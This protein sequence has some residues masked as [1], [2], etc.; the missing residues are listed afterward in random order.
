MQV[1]RDLVIRFK[2]VSPKSQNGDN[3]KRIVPHQQT[4]L[5]LAISLA[6]AIGLT[7]CGGSDSPPSEQL[8]PIATSSVRTSTSLNQQGWRFIF[9]V[10]GSMTEVDAEVALSGGGEAVHLPHTW[11]ATDAASTNSTTDYLRGVGWYRIE[12]N[13]NKDASSQWLHFDA[14]SIVADVWLNGIN[15]GSHSGAFSAFRFDV[16]SALRHG[17]NTLLVKVNNSAPING[18]DRTAVAPL[19]GDF[20][21]SGGLYRG[22]SL[23]GVPGSAHFA[24]NDL[25]SSGIFVTT[26]SLGTVT[27]MSGIARANASIR[28]K[29]KLNSRRTADAAFTVRTALLD[30]AGQVVGQ[31]TSNISIG[32]GRASELEQV[33]EL[34][35]V[36]LWN[37][38]KDPYLHTVVV[39]VLDT[40][41][42]V[43]D[44]I[45]E[46]IGV[47]VMSFN[48]DTGFILNGQSYPL[49]GVNMHQDQLGKA[50]AVDPADIDDRLNTI[51]DIG[52]NTVRMA[53]Y[54][55]SKYAYEFADNLGLVVWAENGFVDATL[56]AADCQRTSNVPDS[57]SENLKQQT[58]EL[59]RQNFNHASIGMWSIGNEIGN[60]GM[61]QGVDTVTPL[62]RELAV[63]TRQEDPSRASTLADSTTDYPNVGV[64][65]NSGITDTWALNRYFGWY[66]S[67]LD[68][69]NSLGDYL[70]AM[71]A[72]YPNLPMGISEYGA[73]A[74]LTH[75]TDNPMGGVV[76]S[77]DPTATVAR[78]G[79]SFGT[80]LV[81]YQPEGYAN[82]VHE[83]NYAQMLARPYIWGT[84]VWNMF[85][86]GSGIRNEG[87]L[88]GVNT[89]GLVTFDGKTKKDPYYFYK[90]AWRSDIPVVHINGRR[91]TNRAY[92]LTDVRVYSNADS[93]S[94]TLNGV[95][96]GTMT[97]EQCRV[98]GV[99]TSGKPYVVPNV[100][101]YK[102]IRLSTGE[103]NLTASGVRN[104][105]TAVDS[106]KWSL[107][108]DNA[109]NY[110]IAAGQPATGM[111]QGTANKTF[112]SDNFF[113]GGRGWPLIPMGSSAGESGMTVA[114]TASYA[115]PTGMDARDTSIWQT[116]RQ[117][118]AFEYKLPLANGTYAV[119]LGFLEPKPT[120]VIGSRIFDVSADGGS[121]EVVVM[122]G[123]DVL[124]LAGSHR[125]AYVPPPF[126]V[127]VT[128]GLLKLKFTGS[129]GEAVVS[130]IKVVRQ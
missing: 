2:Q 66:F 72:K 44:R 60:K 112:G 41:G 28:V 21:R 31:R 63:L 118:S 9:D 53:H 14:A 92:A 83:Q 122:S 20:N 101:E 121:G 56:T 130:N 81:L 23:I 88:R 123:M 34:S 114:G 26:E 105:K 103:N 57:F 58:I 89:K 75:Q 97:A 3:V 116:F 6:G 32:A 33:I 78:F 69:V 48:V 126:N 1:V 16:T 27:E 64:I 113:T 125:R 40:S 85:D 46:K 102:N 124:A 96:L 99:D 84:Y 52:A 127:V 42:N 62:A 24:L 90:A 107:N 5:I 61:C 71:H 74:A 13:H 18:A 86:F 104:G 35:N 95:S 25:G 47:R 7:A 79:V 4:K 117:G 17:S 111:R 43:V 82:F 87:D 45:T 128:N 93:T 110:Y 29:S 120:A 50:W 10:T 59:I 38:I 12:F 129:T 11:N 94:L 98:T 119:T 80:P 106:V 73:G 109:T 51:K 65:N 36:R 76:A 91:Y 39:D 15:L 49:R 115:L 54:Q 19:M 22:V 55:H 8:A 70:D 77:F 37:G 68:K 100:C 108:A 67:Y 30:V